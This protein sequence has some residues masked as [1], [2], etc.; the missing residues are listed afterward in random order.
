MTE[1]QWMDELNAV[2]IRTKK[3]VASRMRDVRSNDWMA[4]DTSN[5]KT[6]RLNFYS[7]GLTNGEERGRRGKRGMGWLIPRDIQSLVAGMPRDTGKEP[8]TTNEFNSHKLPSFYKHDSG[9]YTLHVH[10]LIYDAMDSFQTI[11][12]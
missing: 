2:L 7:Q 4:L 10:N 12:T 1:N 3:S 11:Y 5:N 8:T 6:Q 9:E